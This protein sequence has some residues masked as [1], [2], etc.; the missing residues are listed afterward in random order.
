MTLKASKEVELTK[1]FKS[2]FMEEG[3][4]KPEGEKVLSYLRDVC[5][6]K[7]ELSNGKSY[8]YDNNGR[9]DSG[10]A[11]FLLGRRRVFDLIIKHLGMDEVAIFRLISLQ[12]R[13]LT[14]EQRAMEDIN[15]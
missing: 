8:L 1:A 4:L 2:L 13:S 6:A 7:G 9:F 12:E 5:C 10:A 3:K 15:I 14:D 11:A